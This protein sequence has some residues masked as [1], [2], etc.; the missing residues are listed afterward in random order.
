M[1]DRLSNAQLGAV[2][3]AVI[4]GVPLL[5]L[6]YRSLLP[7][8][9]PGVPH[10]P[11]VSIRGDLPRIM[12]V[13]AEKTFGEYLADQITKLGPI[14]QIF[15]VWD[16][17]VVVSDHAEVER[18]LVYGKNMEQS[19]R[20]IQTFAYVYGH[21]VCGLTVWWLQQLFQMD[22]SH[23]LPHRRLMGPS[24]SKRYLERMSGRITAGANNLARLWGAK[25][26][27]TESGGRV[28]DAD[29]DLQLANMDIIGDHI[30]DIMT[31]TS[32]G[33]ID[34]AYNFLPLSLP[35]S[36]TIPRITTPPS[37]HLHASI[38]AMM[39]S[40][41][42]VS[43][44]VFP[45]LATR[46]EWISPTWRKHYTYLN[47]FFDAKIA[48]AKEKKG[49]DTGLAT[50]TDCVVD[51]A[52]QREGRE[53][54]KMI[55]RGEL[56]D[57]LITYI[58]GGQDSMSSVLAWHVKYLPQV[59]DI[60]RRLHDEVCAVFGQAERLNVEAINDSVRMPVLEAVVA[61]TLR[62]AQVAPLILR[63]LLDDEIILGKFVPRGTQLLFPI[64][65]MSNQESSWGSDASKWN[66]GRWLNSD[67]TF[68]RNAG[69]SF[70]FGF[71]K[72]A[73]FGQRLATLQLKIFIA[74]LSREFYFREVP[75]EVG[76]FD[77][78]K[79]VTRQPKM[80]YVSLE[81]WELKS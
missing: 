62:C 81:K 58:I 35:S 49:E 7:K 72:R 8:P 66:P 29:L 10:D 53:G 22:S 71:G 73:C 77:E 39:A 24:M 63:E 45:P 36:T 6:F 28:F 11:V 19:S 79:R 76:A 3:M 2:V 60:Q 50:D 1:F 44:A 16:K 30:V 42:Y 56:V 37:P 55:G 5:R 40:M 61:E 67:G 26:D 46:L 52:I 31:N 78:V 74:T 47:T 14:F 25:M 15:L 32:G 64:G 23:F 51:M 59:P 38:R 20:A 33:S 54:L 80:C 43:K 12:M 48:E 68:N 17:I 13:T 4:S 9:I 75:Q 70:P 27:L 69:P 21:L 57:E 65:L 41:E 34:A 18:L